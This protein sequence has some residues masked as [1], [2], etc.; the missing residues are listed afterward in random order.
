[1]DIVKQSDNKFLDKLGI[2]LILIKLIF[3]FHN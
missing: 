2:S 3:Y 1:M